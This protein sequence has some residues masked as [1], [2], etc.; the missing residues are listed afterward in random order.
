MKTY[1]AKPSNISKKWWLIDAKN[2]ILGRVAS[3]IALL[4]RGKHKP[5]FTPHMDCGDNVVVINAK[6]VHLTGNKSDPK[7]GTMYYRHTGF[8]GGIKETT[9]GKVLLGKYPERVVKMA[10]KRMISRNSLG[11][12]QLANLYVYA[13]EEH[14]HASQRPILL[15]LAGRNFKNKNNK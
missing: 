10:V 2:L 4:L 7:D 14:P 1:S 15:D 8:P 13:G 11:A 9:A 3:Q 6:Q 12:K 5:T